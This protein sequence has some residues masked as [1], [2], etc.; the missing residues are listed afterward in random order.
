[1]SEVR[2][3]VSAAEMDAM[4]PQERAAA[5]EANVVS[6]WADVDPAFRRSVE[7]KARRLARTLHPES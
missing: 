4:S 5:I 2:K 3:V 1:M 7:E 6:D